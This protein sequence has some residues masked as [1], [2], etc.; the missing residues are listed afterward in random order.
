MASK[1]KKITQQS[2]HNNSSDVLMLGDYPIKRS[3]FLLGSRGFLW[4]WI[5][6]SRNVMGSGYGSNISGG[7]L[8]HALS[9]H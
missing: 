8:P 2:S 3:S 7:S 6:G 9:Y 5:M 1:F 4:V